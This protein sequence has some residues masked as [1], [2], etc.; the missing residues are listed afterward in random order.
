MA[1]TVWGSG[2]RAL[3]GV[4]VIVV[5][6]A[7]VVWGSGVLERSDEAPPPQASSAGEPGAT[8]TL[9]EVSTAQPVMPSATGSEPAAQAD[10]APVSA[11]A[12]APDE[13]AGPQLGFDIVRLEPGGSGLIAGRAGPRETVAI[14]IDGAVL[15]EAEADDFGTFTAFV[16]F[17]PSDAPRVLSLSV[18]DRTSQETVIIAPSAP[19]PVVDA[20]AAD[21]LAEAG[22]AAE[23]A[24]DPSPTP[25]ASVEAPIVSDAEAVQTDS[26][27]T[28]PSSDG[29]SREVAVAPEGTAPTD[30]APAVADVV[31]AEATDPVVPTPGDG[32]IASADGPEEAP[33]VTA[34]DAGPETGNALAD[35]AS[36]SVPEAAPAEAETAPAIVA[37]ADAPLGDAVAERGPAVPDATA[38]ADGPTA[39]PAVASATPELDAAPLPDAGSDWQAPVLISDAAGVRVVPPVTPA[40]APEVMDAVSLDTITYT[41]TGEVAL[42]GRAEPDAFVQLYLDN[43]PLVVSGVGPD[44]AWTVALPEV[45]TGVYTLRVDEISA[46]GEVT[47]RIETPFRREEPE[48]VA[49]V[50]AEA[51]AEPGFEVAVRTVQ[52]GNTLWAIS[53]ERYGQGILYVEIYEANRDLIRNPDLIYPGQVFRLPELTDGE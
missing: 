33:S 48:V 20:P 40:A 2:T 18:G 32:A 29:R 10:P 8:A 30:T 42:G 52:P 22:G 36:Q 38:T 1:S 11:G 25:E 6:V 45:D 5:A 23:T 44:G 51:T 41:P 19:P 9:G 24:P 17:A 14:L 27:V 4:A 47:S 46:E 3:V 28:T 16:T 13:A 53:R 49:E 50:M 26:N 34:L 35:T 21:L 12:Q 39:P 31:V 7:A 37:T 15:T 43:R